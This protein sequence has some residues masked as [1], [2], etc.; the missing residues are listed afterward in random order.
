MVKIAVVRKVMKIAAIVVVKATVEKVVRRQVIERRG[1]QMVK[2]AGVK[3][4]MKIAA[5]AVVKATV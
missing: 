1:M 5:I 3:K 2:I 4:V